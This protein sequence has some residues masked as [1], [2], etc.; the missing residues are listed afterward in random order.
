MLVAARFMERQLGHLPDVYGDHP[1]PNTDAPPQALHC[2]F[3]DISEHADHVER[4][5]SANHCQAD[6]PILL[7]EMVVA[8]DAVGQVLA[9]A[10]MLRTLTRL[11]VSVCSCTC[12]SLWLACPTWSSKASIR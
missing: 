9:C 5:L 8:G 4:W 10:A 1:M 11:L 6:P 2:V 12:Q 7:S 3:R